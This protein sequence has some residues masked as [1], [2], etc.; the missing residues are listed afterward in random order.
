MT[1]VYVRK[2]RKETR[3]D[4]PVIH[5]SFGPKPDNSVIK[6]Q[7]AQFLT[8]K[9]KKKEKKKKKKKKK[10]RFFFVKLR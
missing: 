9:E 5:R 10:K 3:E 2:W 8:S 7:E 4:R 1:R 6:K